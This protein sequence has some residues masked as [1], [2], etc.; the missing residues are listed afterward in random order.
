MSTEGNRLLRVVFGVLGS[1][2]CHYL[3]G[4][5]AYLFSNRSL[6]VIRCWHSCAL[7]LWAVYIGPWT[8]GHSQNRKWAYFF[9]IQFFFHKNFSPHPITFDR[10]VWKSLRAP[11]CGSNNGFDRNTHT[12]WIFSTNV[13]SFPKLNFE[14]L[15]FT[16]FYQKTGCQDLHPL[17]ANFWRALKI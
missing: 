7:S 1:H 12:S 5:S 17:S 14:L 13:P 8:C 11:L 9:V 3:S 4:M 10:L 16:Q 15:R 2:V 6:N